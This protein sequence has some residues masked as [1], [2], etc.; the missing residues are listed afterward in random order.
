MKKQVRGNCNSSVHIIAMGRKDRRL[1]SPHDGSE[2]LCKPVSSSVCV[3]QAVSFFE[4]A[5]LVLMAMASKR[6]DSVA[7]CDP[8]GRTPFQVVAEISRK[9]H[10]DLQKLGLRS[11]FLAAGPLLDIPGALENGTLRIVPMVS[12]HKEGA[13]IEILPLPET[14]Q[15]ASQNVINLGPGSRL[16]KRTPQPVLYILDVSRMRGMEDDRFYVF[17]IGNQRIRRQR[18]AANQLVAVAA[19]PAKSGRDL[20]TE[21]LSCSLGMSGFKAVGQLPTPPRF[22]YRISMQPPTRSPLEPD[23]FHG[24]CGGYSQRKQYLHPVFA[25]TN[26]SAAH[27]GTP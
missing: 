13:A 5:I 11:L 10:G 27:D 20:V 3:P 24:V 25:K 8:S 15:A 12:L 14:S 26:G 16:H 19:R 23:R 6:L 18:S 21:R 1:P 2:S 7:M 17:E 4:S 22:E 9:R